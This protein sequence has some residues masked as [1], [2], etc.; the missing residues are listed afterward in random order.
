MPDWLRF[1][2]FVDD[3]DMVGD[4]RQTY[5]V[6][7][8]PAR[9]LDQAEPAA[10]VAPPTATTSATVTRAGSVLGTPAYMG[11]EQASG[12]SSRIDARSDVWG[13]GAVLKT[14]AASASL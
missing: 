5:L 7:W 3:L 8:G 12:D 2:L 9:H 14:R 1:R 10:V 4:F 13:L 6:D 11:P